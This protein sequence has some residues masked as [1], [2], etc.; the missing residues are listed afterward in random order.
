MG[1]VSAQLTKFSQRTKPE[2]Q[3]TTTAAAVELYTEKIWLKLLFKYNN[4]DV[5]LHLKMFFMI[6]W[7]IKTFRYQIFWMGFWHLGLIKG[8]HLF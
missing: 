6:L 2:N 7:N 8:V 4:A 5:Y 3:T 1:G